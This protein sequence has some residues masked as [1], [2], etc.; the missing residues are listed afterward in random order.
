MQPIDITILIVNQCSIS[1]GVLCVVKSI[2]KVLVECVC[3]VVDVYAGHHIVYT[4]TV[5]FVT[6][7]IYGKLIVNLYADKLIY[8]VHTHCRTPLHPFGKMNTEQTNRDDQTKWYSV[9][10]MI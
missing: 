8:G 2:N 1:T 10:A 4:I 3:A 6:H 7:R 9:T 5:V